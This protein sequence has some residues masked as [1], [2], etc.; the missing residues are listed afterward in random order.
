MFGRNPFA[1]AYDSDLRGPR[2]RDVRNPSE[3]FHA[4]R[5]SPNRKVAREAHEEYLEGVYE[6]NAPARDLLSRVV[7]IAALL[8]VMRRRITGEQLP[9]VP[10]TPKQVVSVK[11]SHQPDMWARSTREEAAAISFAERTRG[12]GHRAKKFLKAGVNPWSE[13]PYTQDE[14]AAVEALLCH[15]SRKSR[16]RRNPRTA[17]RGPRPYR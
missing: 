2:F 16:N 11:T 5:L 9:E 14:I 13:V 3:T 17:A 1:T 7:H 10:G 8:E 15:P 12:V 6:A 4:R